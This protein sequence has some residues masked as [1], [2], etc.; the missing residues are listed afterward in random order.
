MVKVRLFCWWCCVCCIVLLILCCCCCLRARHD[1]NKT[2]PCGMIKVFLIEFELNLK[3]TYG[4]CHAPE[5]S[6]K[7]L[8]AQ[9]QSWEDMH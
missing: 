8:S 3:K 7:S 6:T 4:D 2:A 5:A 9:T 1:H